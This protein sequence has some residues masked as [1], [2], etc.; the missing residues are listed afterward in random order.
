MSAWQMYFV[1]IIVSLENCLFGVALMFGA[2]A[3]C[4]SFMELSNVEKR[5]R[6]ILVKLCIVITIISIFLPSEKVLLA[7]FE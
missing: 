6:N 1:G 5:G 4:V 3:F 2:I 7:I